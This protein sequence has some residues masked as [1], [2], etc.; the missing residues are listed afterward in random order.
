M[1]KN[2]QLPD[3]VSYTSIIIAPAT[4][5]LAKDKQ[6]KIQVV[7]QTRIELCKAREPELYNNDNCNSTASIKLQTEESPG[8]WSHKA[9]GKIKT[10]PYA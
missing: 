2:Q 6:K 7:T 3:T 10:N 4:A 1:A 5:S 8:V 9:S